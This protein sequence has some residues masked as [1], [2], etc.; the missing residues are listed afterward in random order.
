M[1]AARWT[2]QRQAHGTRR[3]VSTTTI[4]VVPQLPRAL[5]V[6]AYAISTTQQLQTARFHHDIKKCARSPAGGYRKISP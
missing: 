6:V 2:V 1:S 5:V 3:V 4:P